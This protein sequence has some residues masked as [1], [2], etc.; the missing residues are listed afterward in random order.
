MQRALTYPG[1][2]IILGRHDRVDLSK[3]VLHTL[4][5]QIFPLFGMRTPG[6]QSTENRAVYDLPNGSQ[7]IPL[8]LREMTKA[9]SFE[10]T[11]AYVNEATECE[12]RQLLDLAATLR[13]LQSPDHP[14]L[15]DWN[16][17]IYDQNPV[18]PGYWTNKLMQPAD[19]ALRACSETG[20]QTPAQYAALQ[21]FNWGAM[22]KRGR[23]PQHKRLITKHMDNPGYWDIGKWDWTPLGRRYVEET[24]STYSG[25]TAD[26]WLSG[27]WVAAEGT[28]FPEF[29][30]KKNVVKDFPI[31]EDWPV[32][33]CVDPGY[34]HPCGVSWNTLA[35]N[36]RRYTI[37]EI[38]RRET[39]LDRLVELI[40]AKHIG[41]LKGYCDPAGKSR[42]QEADGKSFI[43]QMRDRGIRLEPWPFAAMNDHDTCVAAHRQAIVDE[44]YKIFESCTSMIDEHESWRFKRV[45]GGELPS[46]D[47][48]YEDGNNDLIDGELGWE[49][50]RPT[51]PLVKAASGSDNTAAVELTRVRV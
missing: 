22:P 24:L 3:T 47:D 8:G 4:E 51:F 12:Q 17:L 50:T 38:K 23:W 9:Q 43:R 49:R 16:Q 42:R 29:S 35:P 14:T 31:P 13:H 18:H 20:V 5:S 26:R 1:S 21:K 30:R 6:N 7:F 11:F 10:A 44:E 25:F 32:W 36:G 39:G 34:D 33:M 48:Q 37:A 40:N 46:G 45:R 41:V 28:V 15:P 19:D 2:R 27:K